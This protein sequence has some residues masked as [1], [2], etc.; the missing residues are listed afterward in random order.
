MANNSRKYP[1]TLVLTLALLA[2]G[3]AVAGVWMGAARPERDLS[4]G[5]R[6]IEIASDLRAEAEAEA[7]G[8]DDRSVEPMAENELDPDTVRAIDRGLTFLAGTQNRDGSWGGGYGG[9]SSAAITGICGMAFLAQG[10]SPGR[11]K[12]CRNVEKA[13]EWM[14]KSSDRTGMLH[15]PQVSHGSMYG[16]GFATLFLAE[17]YGMTSDP[18]LARRLRI[19]LRAAIRLICQVQLESGGWWYQPSKVSGRTSDISVTICQTMALRAARVVGIN[20]PQKNIDRAVDCVKRAA[21]NDGG[22]AYQVPERVKA[23]GGSAFPRSA[24]GVCILYGLGQYES[25]E[26]LAGVKYL[27]R[28]LPNKGYRTGHYFYG[29]YYAAQAMYQAGGD[30]WSKWWPA[31]RK[32]LLSKQQRNG[33]WPGGAGENY[34]T[35]MACIIL[36]IPYRYLPI[37]QR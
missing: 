34:A 22:F 20:V 6:V 28:N 1:L 11:G 24:A 5:S 7:G 21:Q 8:G 10:N 27:M 29:N 13:L 25:K 4:A 26:T 19:K 16:H 23:S 18:R 31:I 12:Y 2:A 37:L 30:Y 36:A 35:G 33:S 15:G 17:A 14:L 3:T 9:G 32:D